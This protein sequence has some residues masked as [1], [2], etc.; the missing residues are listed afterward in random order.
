MGNLVKYRLVTLSQFSLC[1]HRHCKART[2][3]LEQL[4]ILPAAS[5]RNQWKVKRGLGRA[6]AQHLTDL[7][8]VHYTVHRL[9]S[10]K[11]KH[12]M[13][14]SVQYLSYMEE[15]LVSSKGVCPARRKEG[16]WGE[17]SRD[18]LGILGE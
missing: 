8:S 12:T 18:V 14:K 11:G 9:Y 5:A 13:F 10:Y 17:L 15:Q 7:K 4:R 3:A 2:W 16:Q 6:T 1:N